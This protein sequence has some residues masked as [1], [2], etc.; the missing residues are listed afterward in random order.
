MLTVK[1]GARFFLSQKKERERR[2]LPGLLA[3]EE[4]TGG[5]VLLSNCEAVVVFF[6][7]LCWCGYDCSVVE[8]P[9]EGR[10][11]SA[12]LKVHTNFPNSSARRRQYNVSNPIN[13]VSRDK[14]RLIALLPTEPTQTRPTRKK[15]EKQI[16][17]RI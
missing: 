17:A 5:V 7:K 6:I 11:I 4:R 13:P 1:R 3:G 10:T 15:K 8:V 9:E 12:A 2:Q 16:K 14:T